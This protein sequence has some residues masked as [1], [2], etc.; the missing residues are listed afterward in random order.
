MCGNSSGDTYGQ[1]QDAQKNKML[2]CVWVFVHC[3]YDVVRTN[4]FSFFFLAK[5]STFLWR[6]G[7]FSPQKSQDLD[8]MLWAELGLGWGQ[9]Q[10]LGNALWQWKIQAQVCECVCVS[11]CVSLCMRQREKERHLHFLCII[12][13]SVFPI[14]GQGES[15]DLGETL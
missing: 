13:L 9:G 14:V 8:F 7:F 2:G 15:S 6:Y 4:F 10:G 11:V 3:I 5:I 1:H 12:S